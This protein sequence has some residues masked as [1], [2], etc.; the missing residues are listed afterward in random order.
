MS[1]AAQALRES[2]RRLPVAY[3]ALFLA[4]GPAAGSL[5][6]AATLLDPAVGL[7]GL[8][9]GF[10]AVAVRAGLRMPALAG[11]AEVLNAVYVGLVLGAFHAPDVRLLALALAGGALV[12]PLGSAFGP[13]LRQA[14]DLPLLGAPF[15]CAAWTLLPAARAL[16]I[17]LRGW[18]PAFLFPA[19]I[20]PQASAALSTLGALFYV[21]NPLSG[22]VLAFAVLLAS[23]GLGLA[24][25][26]GGALAW[27]LVAAGGVAAGSALPVLAAFNGALTALVLCTRATPSGR[28]LVAIAGGVVAATLLSAALW[29]TLWPLGLPPLSAPFLLA[30]WLVRAAL[31]ADQSA[32]WSRFWLPAPARPEDSLGRQRL[33]KARGVDGTS[34]GLRLPFAGRMDVSQAMDGAHT[35][36]GPW[37]YALDFVRTENGLSF[38]GD[39]VQLADFHSF[40]L[41]VLSP[42][43]GTVLSCRND[44]PDNAPGEIN[45]RDNWGN[46][47]L[48][49]VHGDHGV[50]LAHLRQGSVAVQPGQWVVPGM[51]IGACGNSGRSTQPHL[52]LHVQQGGWLGAPTRP[53]HLSG[54]R[55]VDGCLVLDGTPARGEALET[56]SPNPGLAQAFRLPAGR[57][58]RFAV[59]GGSWALAVRIGLFGETALVSDAQARMQACHGDLLFA[60]HRRDGAPDPVFDAFALA[61]GLT[62]LTE[63]D[64]CWRDAPTIDT[65]GITAWQRLR[66]ALRNPLRRNFE[67]RYQRHWDS[68]RRL[69]VQHGRHR[70]PALG[71]DIVAESDGYLSEA[72]GPVGFRLSMAG[73]REI[74]AGLCGIGNRGDHGIPA[75]SV[76][77]G[78]APGIPLLTP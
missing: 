75:W 2:G 74:R 10:A 25:V 26:A 3:G 55:Q 49:G 16:G 41:P 13:L 14:R 45:L 61:F 18:A 67:S 46:H 40:D 58:W 27:G 12:V 6:L 69:W 70:L 53:F 50:L 15:L 56:P 11:E 21:A 62:P 52:H 77:Q 38:G 34:I 43:W 64:C 32:F 39:G 47:V 5:V 57:E 36:C 9:A 17:P 59:E 29:W 60:L 65:L 68:R 1:S 20:A 54:Y 30:V 23:P 33:A 48:I 31:R 8:A 73:R 71:G 51:R 35:H 22:A 78:A 19:W 63:G 76:G 72:S 24:A 4:T 37:R 7:L 66:V 44:V 42:A 28:S